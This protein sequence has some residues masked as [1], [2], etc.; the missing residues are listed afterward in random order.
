MFSG[1]EDQ[2]ELLS[3]SLL[4]SSPSWIVSNLLMISATSLVVILLV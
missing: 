4:S 1:Q 3:S 2:N